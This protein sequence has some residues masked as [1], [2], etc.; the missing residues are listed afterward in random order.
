MRDSDNQYIHRA[1][2]PRIVGKWREGD[3]PKPS[4]TFDRPVFRDLIAVLA[5]RDG[6]DKMS[7]GKLGQMNQLYL[8]S[9]MRIY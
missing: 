5:V 2:A 8:S 6:L 1:D 4:I 3:L 7:I 9:E